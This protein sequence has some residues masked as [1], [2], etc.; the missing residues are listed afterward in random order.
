MKLKNK[1][2]ISSSSITH[3]KYTLNLGFYYIWSCYAKLYCCV[4]FWDKSYLSDGDSKIN[5]SEASV[6][7]LNLSS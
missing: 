1:A 7:L 2:I 3:L 6:T 4:A 5:V